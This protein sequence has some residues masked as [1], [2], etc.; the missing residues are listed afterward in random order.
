MMAAFWT[1]EEI[2]FSKDDWE[3]QYN[4]VLDERSLWQEKSCYYFDNCW[5]PSAIFNFLMSEVDRE[6]N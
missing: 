4:A 6:I 3:Q 1:S 2:D 5:S